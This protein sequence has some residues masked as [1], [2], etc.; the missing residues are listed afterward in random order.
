VNVPVSTLARR[1]IAILAPPASLAR[2]GIPKIP[3][4]LDRRSDDF[5]CGTGTSEGFNDRC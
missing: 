2:W 4:R 3:T 5:L 1:V